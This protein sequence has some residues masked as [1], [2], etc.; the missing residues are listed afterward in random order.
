MHSVGESWDAFPAKDKTI[1]DIDLNK[2]ETYIQYA[3]ST[4]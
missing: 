2:V 1:E 4:G 3:N